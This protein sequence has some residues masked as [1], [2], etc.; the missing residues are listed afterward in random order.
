MMVLTRNISPL[1]SSLDK[2]AKRY[3]DDNVKQKV[4]GEI[5]F[6]DLTQTALFENIPS[7]T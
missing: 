3:S 7:P 1:T 6:K 5:K 4:H 2:I